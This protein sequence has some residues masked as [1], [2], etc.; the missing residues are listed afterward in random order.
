MKYIAFSYSLVKPLNVMTFDRTV[1]GKLQFNF[2]N[3]SDF[4][5]LLETFN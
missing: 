2:K 1:F 4:L 3:V 5:E